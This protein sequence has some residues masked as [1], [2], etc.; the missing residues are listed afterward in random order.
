MKLYNLLSAVVFLLIFSTSCKETTKKSQTEITKIEKKADFKTVA[1]EIEGMTCQIGCAKTIESKLSKTKGIKSATV[2]FEK[3]SGEF[4]Y[5]A[6]QISKEQIAEKISAIAGG[7][8]YS[9]KGI[10][11]I[12]KKTCCATKVASCKKK[13]SDSCTK[14]DCEKCATASAECKTKCD[15]KLIDSKKAC[16][17][18]KS[19]S[20]KKKCSDSCTKKDCEKC[21]ITSAECKTKCDAK[22]TAV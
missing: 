12:E 3:K 22:N 17:A 19:E 7:K 14:K 13:C 15:A 11:S 10:S 1:I 2:T 6:N 5:D 4:T 20:C 21:A 9:T 18:T 8:T 16:S